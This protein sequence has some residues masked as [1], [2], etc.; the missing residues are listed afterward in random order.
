[1]KKLSIGMRL[2]LWYVAIF[3]VAQIVFGGGMW[4]LLQHHLYDLVEDGLENQM[5]DLKNFLSSQKSDAS[6]AAL[7]QQI[8]QTYTLEH[9]G[10]YLELYAG[11]G[12]L[13]YRSVFLEE[14]P[15]KLLTPDQIGKPSF[16]NKRI[17]S[18]PLRFMLERLEINGRVYVAMM[19]TPADDMFETLDLFRSYLLIFA[20]ALFLV[21]TLGGYWL[22]RRA[23][24]PVDALVQTARNISGANLQSRLP[25]LATGDE[26]QRLSDTLNQMLDRIE[27]AFCRVTQ[28]TADA[29]HELRT[30]VSLMRTEAEVALRRSRDAA[31]YRDAL[32][33][34]LVEAERTTT[35][36]ERL[37]TLARADAGRETLH[38]EPVNLGDALQGAVAS[39]KQSAEFRQLQ[40]SAQLSEDVF[41][42]GD[43]TGLRHVVDILLDNA[44]KYT[45][46]PGSI[47]L[48]VERVG[49]NAVVAVRDSGPGIAKEEQAKIFERFYRVDASRNRGQGGTG[50]GLA[51][52]KWI[53]AQHDGRITVDSAPGRGSTFRVEIPL[54]TAPVRNPQP[55]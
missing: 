28:F 20:P 21:A 5:E 7:Q 43:S 42:T 27:Q 53:V 29:S 48:S 11:D 36:I 17:A 45:G 26:L 41:V 50:L 18:H 38:M 55:A 16:R 9:P 13:L 30:P 37:L 39:W 2:T 24:S 47:K 40:F 3:A 4:F 33:N 22:S 19:G 12:T 25:R 35:L 23:L 34:I 49:S 54:L 1:M 8:R 15:L 52:A 32:R 46:S 31:D 51:I 44:C 10:D 14:H 6:M